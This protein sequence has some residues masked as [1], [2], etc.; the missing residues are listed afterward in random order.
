M[1]PKVKV[2][3]A[4]SSITHNTQGI[5]SGIM[6][7]IRDK[8]D[9]NLIIWADSSLESLEFLKERGC[10]GAFAHIQTSTKAQ[11]ILKLKMPIIGF[12][13]LQNLLSIPYISADPDQIA[14]TA[15]E[16]FKSKKYS[17]FG[18]FGINE[19]RWSLERMES[20][21]RC[22]EA[23]GGTLHVFQSSP[24]PIRTDSVP[25]AKLWIETI[26]QKG[27]QPFIDWLRGLP[28]P[29][30]ILV[31]ND[32]LACHLSNVAAE[33]GL[34]IP[35]EIAPL[36][37]D[38]D[39]AICDLC[40]P[41][42]S[43]IAFNFKS[44]GY[45]AAQLM[46]DI[47]SGRQ[48][49]RGQWI[50]IQPIGVRERGSTDMYALED[51]ELIKALR[52]IRTHASRPLQVDEIAGQLCISKRTLQLKFQKALGRSIHEEII[53]AHFEL[54]RTLLIETNLPIETVA[55]RS[56]FHYTSNLRRTFLEL[57]GMLPHKYRQTHR[58][59]S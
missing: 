51:E 39:P 53:R 17:H 35:E 22:V 29:I 16:Y 25:V 44:A 31:G 49:M 45:E 14:K 28:K 42:L 57:T 38:D 52:Y 11:Q 19:A 1:K 50:R 56:G 15:Y 54:A 2:A 27:Q 13:T 7:Y 40:T 33:A 10:Q 4:Y 59:H 23:D 6:D 24:R 55:V 46:D 20:F 47:I 5:M 26:L 9:W 21:R 48:E 43:S 36:G 12:S 41:P 3:F 58:L 37:V 32:I 30:A 18:F 8:G 34:H